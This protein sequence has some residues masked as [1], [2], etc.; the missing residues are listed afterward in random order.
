[1]MTLR[2]V[3]RNILRNRRR[4]TMTLLAIAV[5]AIGIVLFGEF[6]RFVNHH[7]QRLFGGIEEQ[8]VDPQTQDV[9]VY[10]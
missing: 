3:F 5:G 2:I 9:P 10:R 4:S 8:F 1:M 6:V 7:L